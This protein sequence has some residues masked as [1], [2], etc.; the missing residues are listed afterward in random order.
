MGGVCCKR[1]NSLVVDVV[2]PKTEKETSTTTR[3]TP[4]SPKESDQE[5]T[6]DITA[7]KQGDSPVVDVVVPKTEKETSTTTAALERTTTQSPKESAQ[8]LTQEIT[9]VK[10]ELVRSISTES[11]G[12]LEDKDMAQLMERC[13][14]YDEV[15]ERTLRTIDE[16]FARFDIDKKGVLEGKEAQACTDA[17][18]AHIMD[19]IEGQVKA[20][21]SEIIPDDPKRMQA[22]VEKKMMKV[23][24][25]KIRQ[26]ISDSVDPNT[27]GKIS[28]DEAKEGFKKVVNMIGTC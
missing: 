9:A 16:I 25:D 18:L 6:Q 15:D 26:K 20:T 27:D 7:V 10:Q 5:L 24:T 12:K 19:A 1:G 23:S 8:E 4:Q 2:V 17:L 3:T 13:K 21:I 11:D 14:K 28:K 22:E